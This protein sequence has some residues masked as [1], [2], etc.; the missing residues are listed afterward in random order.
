MAVAKALE[1]TSKLGVRRAILK[2]DSLVV[3]KALHEDE[4]SLSPMGLLLEDVRFFSQSFEELLYSR[5][6]REGIVVAH[7]LTR[8][9]NSIS[10]FSV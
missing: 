9:T 10:D 5:T 7:S 2:G 4:Q 8:Y 6:K 1:F 3:V